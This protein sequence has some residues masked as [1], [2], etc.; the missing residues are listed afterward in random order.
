M[1]RQNNKPIHTEN[2]PTKMMKPESD[3]KVYPKLINCFKRINRK[4]H[5]PKNEAQMIHILFIPASH[6]FFEFLH[7]ATAHLHFLLTSIAA[8]LV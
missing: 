4:I 3:K 7:P 6:I 1:L 8:A 5:F 2:F